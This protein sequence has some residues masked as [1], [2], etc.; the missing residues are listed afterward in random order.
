MAC[1]Q[2][3]AAFLELFGALAGDGCIVRV[4]RNK[5]YPGYRIFITGNAKTDFAYLEQLCQLFE[6]RGVHAY[7]RKR[8]ATNKGN[9]GAA[10]II[11]NNDDFAVELHELGFPVGKKG[12]IKLPEWI[13]QRPLKEQLRV[14]RGLFDTDGFLSARKSE[15]YRRPF[16]LISSNSQPLRTQVRTIL[17]AAGLPAYNSSGMVGVNGTE[18]TKKWFSSVGSSNE[19]NLSRYRAWLE[20]GVL[21]PARPTETN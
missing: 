12:N 9:R 21:P 5:K 2:P 8:K 4:N 15:G 11:I 1:I 3:D 7:L 16:A 19:R 10:D 17:R 18:N 6:R 14:I 20:T 13:M